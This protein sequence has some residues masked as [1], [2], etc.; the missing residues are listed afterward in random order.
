M[1]GKRRTVAKKT[2]P[3]RNKR[4]F[5]GKI[6]RG[7]IF[8]VCIMI[9]LM[10]MGYIMVGGTIPEEIP[11]P[12]TQGIVSVN[13]TQNYPQQLALQLHT[14]TGVTNTPFP[15]LGGAAAQPDSIPMND[16]VCNDTVTSANTIWGYRIAATPASNGQRA[17]QVFFSGA[18]AVS[19]GTT[20]QTTKPTQHITNP[21]ANAGTKDPNGY[22]ISA[23][24]Y[25]TEVSTNPADVS[26]DAKSGGVPQFPSDVYGTWQTEAG[27]STEIANGETLGGGADLWP[28]ANGPGGG[29]NNSGF[30][31]SNRRA[32]AP[33]VIFISPAPQ[34]S[35]RPSNN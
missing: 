30:P 5:L 25:V 24:V 22:P 28:P 32:T 7:T 11:K 34:S 13:M 29:A 9:C 18:N 21:P 27:V 19:V 16:A 6:D 4:L 33:S 1:K 14:F 2:K 20:A 8:I 3:V 10:F 31:G 12:R 23:S 35:M 26:G 15:T 17:L